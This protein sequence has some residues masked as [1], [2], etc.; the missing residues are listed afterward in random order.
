M[1]T[2]TIDNGIIVEDAEESEENKVEVEIPTEIVLRSRC[3]PGLRDI[4]Q[5]PDS[6]RN[7]YER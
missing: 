5:P 2:K 4:R 3:R 6:Y 1:P 7:R